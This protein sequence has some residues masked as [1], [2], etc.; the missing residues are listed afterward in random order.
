M[1]PPISPRP[2]NPMVSWQC[3]P[4]IVVDVFC[5][6]LEVGGVEHGVDLVGASGS[7]RSP[8][9]PPGC[10]ASRR[11]PP[12][13]G[14]CRGDPRQPQTLD[15]RQVPGELGLGE[16]PVVLAPIVSERGVDPL[17]GH[18]AGEHSGAHRGV[19]DHA[20]PVLALS[21]GEDRARCRARSASTAAGASRPARSAGSAAAARRRGSRRRCGGRAPAP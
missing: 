10:E 15:Q 14:R 5:G 12:I 19:D 1:P 11:W 6:E 17:A 16:P 7:R 13:P 9:R 8:R 21:E 20:D 2:M 18:R 4:S 3:S